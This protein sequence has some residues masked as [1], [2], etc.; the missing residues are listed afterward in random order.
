[1]R[2]P[3]SLLFSRLNKP[4]S[5][6]LSSQ[7]RCSRPS[8]RSQHCT[9]LTRSFAI[10]TPSASPAKALRALPVLSAEAPPAPPGPGTGGSSHPAALEAPRSRAGPGHPFSPAP[11]PGERGQARGAGSSPPAAPPRALLCPAAA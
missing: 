10:G 8:P 6:S 11:P 9:Q 2:S 3:L 4:S 7:E 1:M 5:L